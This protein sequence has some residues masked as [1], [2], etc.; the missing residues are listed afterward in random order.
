MSNK[1]PKIVFI[2]PYRNRKPQLV[3]Y[4]MYMTKYILEDYEEG[5]YEMYFVHQFDSRPFNRGGMKN[6]GF[7]AIKEKY[8]NDYKDITFVFNDVDTMPS[9]KDLLNYETNHGYIKHFYGFEYTIGGIVSVTGRDFE[10]MNGFPNYWAWG[11][12]DNDLQHRVRLSNFTIDRRVFF[13]FGDP[14]IISVY[15]GSERIQSKQQP[16]RCGP[17]NKEG[18]TDIRNLKYSF[19]NDM[20]NVKSFIT[21]FDPSSDNYISSNNNSSI[22]FDNRF[23]PNNAIIN[24]ND[25][26]NSNNDVMKVKI[27]R[28]TDDIYKSNNDNDNLNSRYNFTNEKLSN[29]QIKFK[30]QNKYSTLNSLNFNKGRNHQ[31]NH[32][33]KLF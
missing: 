15:T 20:I 12:E 6:I 21:P 16:W 11:L 13:K 26:K 4:K 32:T 3:H 33:L 8:P 31:I 19:E 28:N 14:N 18:I 5:D 9:S 10:I 27:L 25:I 24:Q 17:K 22:K 2:I 7:I 1:I 29:S 23:R 30:N